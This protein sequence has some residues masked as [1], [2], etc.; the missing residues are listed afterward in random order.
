M[1]SRFFD[2]SKYPGSNNQNDRL[3]YM[4]CCGLYPRRF[5][6]TLEDR[7]IYDEYQEVNEMFMIWEGLIGIGYAKPCAGTLELPYR[8]VKKQIG[9]QI[10][11]D[12]YV[13]NKKKSQ[14]IYMALEE[15][16]SYA[17]KREYLHNVIFP[18]FPD[19]YTQAS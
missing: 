8:I 5:K 12:H 7:L 4:I 6:P 3:I 15:V 2:N 13:I 19:V 1:F 14:W 11:C 17:L 9:I 10:I 16:K 18:S